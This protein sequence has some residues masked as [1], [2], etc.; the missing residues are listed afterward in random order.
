VKRLLAAAVALA[1]LTGAVL[2]A[3]GCGGGGDKNTYRV[4]AIFDSAGF[5][6][7]ATDVRIGGAK[8]GKVID[9]K[10]TRDHKAR[11]E[12]EVE[13][14][15]A[16]FRSDADC[17]IQPQSLISEKFV[18]CTPGTPDGA[19]LRE[20]AGIPVLPVANTHAPIDIDLLLNIFDRPVR[21]RLTLLLSALGSGLAARGDDLNL[22]IRRATPALQETQRVLRVL[23]TDRAQLRQLI[24]DSDVVLASLANGR[25]RVADFVSSTGSVAAVS[26]ARR[27]R[28]T[29]AVREL[30]RLLTEARSGLSQLTAFAKV[31]TPFARQLRASGPGVNQLVRE[32]APFAKRVTPTVRRLGLT[33]RRAKPALKDIAPQARRLNRFGKPLPEASALLSELGTSVRERG[34]VEGLGNLGYFGATALARFDKHSHILPSYIIAGPCAI[35]ATA[36]TPGCDAHYDA[37]TAQRAAF[38]RAQDAKQ[39]AARKTKDPDKE[40]PAA[41]KPKPAAP[42]TPEI[43]KTPLTPKV[44]A[45]PLPNLPKILGDVLDGLGDTLKGK[46]QPKKE[47]PPASN[48]VQDLLDYLLR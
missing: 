2:L 3:T 12:L 42:A 24:S 21:E 7:E 48:A 30:P 34:V 22:T 40:A 15:F 9:L 31:G 8:V 27:E 4:D 23:D 13:R 19:A 33:A 37:S 18:N 41:A 16:P 45:I 46:G 26:G 17:T 14:R 11:V 39:A 29:E 47:Q 20:Q 1:L 6:T 28:L 25:Q 44:P 35:W 43:P 36:P 32:L 5:L 10:L 38:W